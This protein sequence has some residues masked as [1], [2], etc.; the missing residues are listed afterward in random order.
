MNEMQSTLQT[1]F[2]IGDSDTDVGSGNLRSGVDRGS[3]VHGINWTTTRLFIGKGKKKNGIR[4]TVKLNV[5][6][7]RCKLARTCRIDDVGRYDVVVRRDDHGSR[8][9]EKKKMASRAYY[10][11]VVQGLNS[12][13]VLCTPYR[14]SNTCSTN[15]SLWA[16]KENVSHEIDKNTGASILTSRWVARL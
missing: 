16:P 1:V 9:S 3:Q 13:T 10:S 5:P 8:T 12:N 6:R 2:A 7:Y 15:Y 4:L 14:I 11:R